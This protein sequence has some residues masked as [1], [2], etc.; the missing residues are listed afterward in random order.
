MH[1]AALHMLCRA[2]EQ[3]VADAATE[4]LEDGPSAADRPPTALPTARRRVGC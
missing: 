2:V 1:L 3:A 4:R